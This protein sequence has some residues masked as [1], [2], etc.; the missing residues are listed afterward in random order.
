MLYTVVPLFAWLRAP[1]RFGLIVDLACAVLAGVA[2]SAV[3]RRVPRPTLVAAAI[4]VVAI[5]ELKVE[6]NMPDAKPVETVYTVLA[7]LPPGPVIEM[8][9][10]YIPEVFFRHTYLHARVDRS[11]GCRW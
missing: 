7:P 3:L 2:A 5:A 9:F 11:T 4:A 6:L 8:P 1:A 10:F